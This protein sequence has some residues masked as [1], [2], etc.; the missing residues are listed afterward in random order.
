MLLIYSETVTARLK[1][2]ARLI[3]DDLSG[4]ST[5]FTDN[6]DVFLSHEGPRINYSARDLGQGMQIIPASLL[7]ETTVMEITAEAGTS[8]G[9]PALF[10]STGAG[11]GFDVFA[12]SFYMVTRY[13]EYYCSKKD[14]YGRFQAK[15]S[16][17][18]ANGFDHEPVVNRWAAALAGTLRAKWPELAMDPSPYRFVS[19]I[20]VDHAFAYRNRTFTRT[21][22]GMARALGHG[23][24][25][26]IR[27]RLMVLTG[28]REDPFATYDYIRDFHMKLGILPRYFILFA[29]YGGDDNN[30]SLW[31]KEFRRLLARLADETVVGIHPSLSSH[32]KPE[33]LTAEIEGLATI[34]GREVTCSRQHFLKFSFPKTFRRLVTNG[35]HRRFLHGLC[36]HLRFQGRYRIPVPVFRSEPERSN[37]AQDSPGQ[38]DG[39]HLPRLPASFTR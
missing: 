37:S 12:A 19:T 15:H 38:H 14:R 20:D 23:E 17:A 2:V 39:C 26:K 35:D 6:V 1:Y 32:R 16:I 28:F 34:I 27:E 30:V 11:F 5:T 7:F 36:H 9:F 18:T 29:D 21:L 10:P 13:E 33:R 25:G 3:L 24:F 8:E 31:K 22:G 4:I